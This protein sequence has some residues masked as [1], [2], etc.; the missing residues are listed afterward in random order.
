MK[1]NTLNLFKV[2][3]LIIASVVVVISLAFVLKLGGIEWYRF[4]G[5]KKQS[6]EREVFKETRSYNEAKE[7]ELLKLRLE[8][9][10]EK[11][12]VAKEAIASTIR[13]KFADYPKSKLD[14]ELLR[15]FLLKIKKGE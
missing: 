9:I 13:H 10:K 4:F 8:Y 6:A 2:M 5:V 15:D 12:T 1:S 14:S 3:G 7:Q 11:D